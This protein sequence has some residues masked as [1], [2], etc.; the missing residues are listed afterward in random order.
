MKE[1]LA[2]R[3]LYSQI[4]NQLFQMIPENFESI[5]LYC[6]IM[7]QIKGSPIGEMYFYYFPKGLLKRNPVNVYEIPDKFN[8]VNE[9]YSKLVNNLYL[10]FKQLREEFIRNNE[11]V[12]TN[13][14]VTIENLCFTIEYFYDD[15]T[16]SE[17]SNL[18]RHVIWK[19]QYVQKDLSTYPKKE[20]ELI[21]KY[22]EKGKD[23]KKESS[24]YTEGVYQE[25][26]KQTLNYTT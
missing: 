12:W 10:S 1:T 4:Q 14:T 26:S 21:Q 18:E 16:L 13:L 17:Y 6:S 20:R 19:Y 11:K 8:I 3:R 23:E 25:K 5:Y 24:F 7:E 2:I 15:I 9:A 22:I